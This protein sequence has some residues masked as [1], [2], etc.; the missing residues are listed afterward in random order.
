MPCSLSIQVTTWLI[1]SNDSTNQH[2]IIYFLS[3]SYANM[4][5][6][7][8]K[9][10]TTYCEKNLHRS[11]Y[12][13]P[14]KLRSVI[15]FKM[16]QCCTKLWHI[17]WKS[18]LRAFS[19]YKNELSILSRIRVLSIL[20]KWSYLTQNFVY[21]ISYGDLASLQDLINVR[22]SHDNFSP[23]LCWFPMEWPETA[24]TSEV[25]ATLVLHNVKIRQHCPWA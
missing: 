13:L 9:I 23:E 4:I 11:G 7:K 5:L 12:I 1:I 3:L 18:H 16:L 24:W 21:V 10:I 15:K 20:V 6:S 2:K 14:H 8:D 22:D 25:E 17:K 19:Y